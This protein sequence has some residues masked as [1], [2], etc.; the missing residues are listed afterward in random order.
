MS[1]VTKAHEG[2]YDGVS[3][4]HHSE[5]SRFLFH[6]LLL[7]FCVAAVD[8]VHN[9]QES[10]DDD[11]YG[12]ACTRYYGHEI[13]EREGA[14]DFFRSSCEGASAQCPMSGKAL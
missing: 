13:L 2:C 5:Y 9:N 14:D 11:S 4:T 10:A 6:L 1:K 12:A 3:K 8:R 7:L